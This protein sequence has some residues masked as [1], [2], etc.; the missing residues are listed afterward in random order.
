MYL[1]QP[2]TKKPKKLFLFYSPP[3]AFYSSLYPISSPQLQHI[4]VITLATSD[5]I[6][7]VETK[8]DTNDFAG[9]PYMKHCLAILVSLHLVITGSLRV[10]HW[11]QGLTRLRHQEGV[12]KRCCLAQEADWMKDIFAHTKRCLH[13]CDGHRASI[14]GTFTGSPALRISGNLP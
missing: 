14:Q 10:V 8:W 7:I 9:C 11:I 13:L 3:A 6:Q 2:R 4:A 12:V 1:I 5:D